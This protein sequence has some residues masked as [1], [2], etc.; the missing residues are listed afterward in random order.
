[1]LDQ[2]LNDTNFP[3]IQNGDFNGLVKV[4]KKLMGDSNAVVAGTAVKAAGN[5]A[6]G[7]RKDFEPYVRELIMPLLQKFKEKKT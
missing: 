2:L 6:K 4:I 5:L 3:K 1:M 7:L